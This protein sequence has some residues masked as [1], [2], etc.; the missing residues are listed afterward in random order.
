MGLFRKGKWRGEMEGGLSME[1]SHSMEVEHFGK[2]GSSQKK[3][4][5]KKG[6]FSRFRR[7]KAWIFRGVLLSLVFAAILSCFYGIFRSRAEKYEENPLESAENITWLFQNSYLLYRD[8]R[9]AQ[10]EETLDYRDVYL[11][12]QEKYEWILDESTRQRYMNLLPDI[13]SDDDSEEEPEGGFSD[14]SSKENLE[15]SLPDQE[16]INSLIAQGLIED[17]ELERYKSGEY[18]YDLS[19]DECNMLEQDIRKMD[20][21]FSELEE[22]FADLNSSYDYIIEDNITGKYMTNMSLEDRN[23]GDEEQY[24]R[25]SFQ[26]DEAG[27]VRVGDDVCGKDVSGIRKLA[28]EAV[29]VNAIQNQMGEDMNAFAQYGKIKAPVDCTVT[30]AVSAKEWES[31]IENSRG[32]YVGRQGG[33]QAY[34]PTQYYNFSTDAY[35]DSGLA[36]ILML[37]MLGLA[38]AGMFLPMPEGHRPWKEER[39]CAVSLEFLVCVVGCLTACAN[40]AISMIVYV[41]SGRA[42]GVFSEYLGIDLYRAKE[43]A[44][45]L[46]IVALTLFAFGYWYVGICARALRDLGL[47]RYI[48]QRSL[49]YRFF[50][51]MKGKAVE[52]YEKMAHMDLTKNANKTI[53]KILVVNAVILFLISCLWVGSFPVVLVYSVVLYFILRKYV[54]ELQKRYRI[55]LKAVDEIAQGNLNVSIPEDLGIFEPFREQVFKIQDGLQKAVEAEVKSQRMKVELVTNMSHDLKTPLTAIITYINLLKEKDITPQQQKEYLDTLE[56][57]SLRLKSLI[58]DLFEFSK[59]SSQNVTLNIMDVDIMNLVKQV[60]FEMS[61]KIGEAG[62]D[63][64][65]NLSE[66]KVILPLDSQKTY[67]IYENLFGNIAKYALPGTRVYVNGFRIGDI[68]IITLKN[69][70]AQE[71]TVD[72]SE[73]TERFVRGDASRNTEGSGLG[74]AIAKS[75]MELQGGELMLEVDGDLFKATTT[76]HMP[77]P[78]NLPG[79]L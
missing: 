58:E 22:Y 53:I 11:E 57:K 41:A 35:M 32:I 70:S 60:A 19:W 75:F 59:A 62:L 65:M 36:G 17:E 37:C 28:N 64:R 51:F 30:F 38:L 27:N 47:R 15:G 49:I 13:E 48:R 3:G 39:I 10:S 54:S 6:L 44:M 56:R 73:L 66:E 72:S 69:I 31:R 16:K 24:F 76:W 67:R 2:G 23:R 8:L 20:S 4:A 40:L 68:V 14:T 9:N 5:P 42:G 71:I 79:I 1:E 43:L 46:N 78:D 18:V 34:T 25:L 55:L 26:F 50:P 77:Q 74:L 12:T 33:G 63:V 45:A 52:A 21:Y 7:E 29:R 61:D